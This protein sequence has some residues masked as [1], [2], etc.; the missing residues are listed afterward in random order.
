MPLPREE[1]RNLPA[2]TW[3]R[4][5]APIAA[6]SLGTDFNEQKVKEWLPAFTKLAWKSHDISSLGLL[7]AITMNLAA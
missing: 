4:Q 7:E 1:H 3:P 2:P 5:P 6:F